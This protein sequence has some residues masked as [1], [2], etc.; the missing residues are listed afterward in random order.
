[1]HYCAKLLLFFRCIPLPPLN[2]PLMMMLN[3]DTYTAGEEIRP[4]GQQH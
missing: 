2:P 1:M 3:A 4:L